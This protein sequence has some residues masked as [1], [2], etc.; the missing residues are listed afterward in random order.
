MEAKGERGLLLIRIKEEVWLQ[1]AKPGIIERSD[2]LLLGV[3]TR[4]LDP[5]PLCVRHRR[6]SIRSKMRG[7]L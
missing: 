1:L 2:R 6:S 7:H 4:M 5:C 3:P